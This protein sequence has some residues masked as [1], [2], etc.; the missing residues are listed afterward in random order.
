MRLAGFKAHFEMTSKGGSRYRRGIPPKHAKY[1]TFDEFGNVILRPAFTQATALAAIGGE[2][3]Y[4]HDFRALQ[5]ATRQAIDKQLDRDAKQA[6]R[7]GEF[8]PKNATEGRKKVV[9]AITLRRG[10]SKFRNKLLQAY[11]RRC[12]VTE[13]DCLDALEAAHILPYRGPSTHHV[14]NGI[15]LRSDIHTLFDVGRMGFVPVGQDIRVTLSALLR[16]TVYGKLDGKRLRLPSQTQDRPSE[17][18][19]RRHSEKF[20]LGPRRL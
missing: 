15:L 20:Q 11:S 13:C 9:R 14:Q 16:E 2:S 5:A 7:E 1:F 12:A 10:Q 8:D 4:K 17:K 18:A 3:T 19:L 6:E